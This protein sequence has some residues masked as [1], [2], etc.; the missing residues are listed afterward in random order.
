MEFDAGDRGTRC[1]RAVLLLS[2][3]K[4]DFDADVPSLVFDADAKEDG[5][6]F[7]G[8]ASGLGEFAP[9]LS[10]RKSEMSGGFLE[11]HL[12][13]SSLALSSLELLSE[14]S[15]STIHLAD[16]R[17]AAFSSGRADETG[18]DLGD[19]EEDT[20]V[21]SRGMGEDLPMA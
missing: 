14:S 19:A 5:Y 9:P 17:A 18:R 12:I 10:L 21:R 11:G 15:E 2:W 16:K 4:S 13:A 20:G 6:A 1:W 8:E 7:V 3:P